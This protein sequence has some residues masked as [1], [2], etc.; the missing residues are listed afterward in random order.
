[1][2][3]AGN[4]SGVNQPVADSR[5]ATQVSDQLRLRDFIASDHVRRALLVL[6]SSI[7]F[8]TIILSFRPFNASSDAPRIT[9]GDAV[10]QIGFI[11]LLVIS[12]FMMLTQV[13]SRK[14]RAVAS[15]A[16]ILAL[17]AMAVAVYMSNDSI[18]AGRALA[19]ALISAFVALNII[20]VPA[21][22]RDF[23]AVL[24][25]TSTL[26]IVIS[27]I[28][29]VLFP[30]AAVHSSG[31]YEAQ[32]E[33]LWR[34]PFRHKNI[35]GPIF[36]ILTIFGVYIYRSGDKAMG[37]VI[38]L[39][40][41]IFVLKTG[42]KTTTGFL[43]M[44]I[45]AIL[46]A[47]L[48]GS[49]KTAI[50]TVII[51][52]LGAAL[53]SV[54]TVYSENLK[55]ITSL[56]LDDTTFTGRDDLWHFGIDNVL[57]RPFFG[58]GFDNFWQTDMVKNGVIPAYSKWDFLNIVHGHNS[59]IDTM[60]AFGFV[61]GPIIIFVVYILPMINYVRAYNDPSKRHLADMFMM[62]IAFTILLSLME[63][64]VL[65]RSDP[66]WI[67][68]IFSVFGL[69]ILARTHKNHASERQFQSFK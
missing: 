14:L 4:I 20:M 67:M 39:L 69:Q 48:F 53:L 66:I 63:A 64:F 26:V 56:F 40:S 43:P 7:I 27:Y 37:V 36:S 44:A 47:R 3:Y 42:S 41:F 49:S 18:A 15:P 68:H 54:G 31:G 29:L 16:W 5:G 62:V 65:S 35:A 24:V 30:D 46:T 51:T 52:F 25:L 61:G 6:F 12:G 28:G 33:G 34:G 11:T 50:F 32:H 9:G 60:L 57:T 21:S 17:G 1:M 38:A 23:R 58:F 22:V 13:S 8:V 19:L 2:P 59:Y 10:N 45:F 55:T